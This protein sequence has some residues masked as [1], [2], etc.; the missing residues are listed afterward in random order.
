MK[1]DMKGANVI[2]WGEM[3]NVYI[4]LVRKP[5]GKRSRVIGKTVL[6]LNS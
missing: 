6:K 1:E 3:R 4:R 5:S 2:G